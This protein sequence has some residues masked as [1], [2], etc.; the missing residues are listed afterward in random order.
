MKARV[1]RGEPGLSGRPGETLDPVDFE[2]ATATVEKFV[3]RKPARRDVISYLLY[4]KV[5]R[6]FADHQTLYSDTSVLPTPV[7]LYG[8]ETGEEIAV[9]I[10]RGKTL[11]VNFL[12]VGEPH[13]DGRG[14]RQ[15]PIRIEDIQGRG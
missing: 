13:P 2:E 12:T 14:E 9:D 11:I 10:E 1:L 4:P 7:F 8:Q 5:Y 15:L 3:G 6:E